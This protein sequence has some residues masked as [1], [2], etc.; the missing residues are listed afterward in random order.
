MTGTGSLLY[1]LVA[2]AHCAEQSFAIAAMLLIKRRKHRIAEIMCGCLERAGQTCCDPLLGIEHTAVQ[3]RDFP[4]E[5]PISA[6]ILL[7]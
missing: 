2:L 6:R 4:G 1:G 3:S 7:A 5:I